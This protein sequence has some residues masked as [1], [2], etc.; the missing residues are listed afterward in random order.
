MQKG[1]RNR[2]GRKGSNQ[3]GCRG[4]CPGVEVCR[5][6]TNYFEKTFSEYLAI[7]KDAVIITKCFNHIVALLVSARHISGT[8][9]LD[10]FI[11]VVASLSN[12]PYRGRL[13]SGTVP[14]GNIEFD[15]SRFS[16]ERIRIGVTGDI[17]WILKNEVIEKFLFVTNENTPMFCDRGNEIAE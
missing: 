5:L 3:I 10:E 6:L 14:S 2:W 11:G 8:T 13:G 17:D 16:G 15:C 9:N 7:P 4:G 12:S 1:E